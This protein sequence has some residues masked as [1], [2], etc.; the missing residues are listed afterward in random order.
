[1]FFATGSARTRQ[2][3][4]KGLRRAFVF[5]TTL[6]VSLVIRLSVAL[7]VGPSHIANLLVEVFCVHA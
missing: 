6:D 2:K 5:H 1:M 4:S 7:L 3:V